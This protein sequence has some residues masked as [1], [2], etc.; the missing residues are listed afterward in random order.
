MAQNQKM[1]VQGHGAGNRFSRGL[2]PAE[3]YI[4]P[5]PEKPSA[6]HVKWHEE[7]TALWNEPVKGSDLR[8]STIYGDNKGAMLKFPHEQQAQPEHHDKHSK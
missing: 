4:E 2:Q 7:T 5:L 1:E 3:Q 6:A 8:T